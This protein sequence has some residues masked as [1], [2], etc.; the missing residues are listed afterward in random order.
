MDLSRFDTRERAHE[1]VSVPLVIDGET[2]YGDD[3][4]PVT[5]QLRGIADPDVHKVILQMRKADSRTPEEVVASDLKLARVACVGWSDN[6]GIDQDD[7]GNLVKLPFSKANVE[8]VFAIP[9]IR[10]AVLSECFR[11]ANFMSKG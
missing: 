7:K 2:V 9:A 8:K 5:F 10:K 6:W 3:D 1:G 4:K 11:E